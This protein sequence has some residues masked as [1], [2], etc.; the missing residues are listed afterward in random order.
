VSDLSP[1]LFP[2]DVVADRYR[3]S[4]AIGIGGSG[5]VYRAHQLGMKQEIAL[6]V[7]HA[8]HPD[9]VAER[10]RFAR[11]AEMVKRLQ[12]PHVVPLLDYGHGDDGVPFLVFALLIGQSLEAK[13]KQEGPLGWQATAKVS[14]QVLRALD[15]A[16]RLDI[17]HRD[18]KPA[19]IFMCTGV[20]GEVA[21]VLDFGL[22]KVVGKGANMDVTVAGSLLGT[23]RYMA[24]EQVRGQELGQSAD[25]YSFGLVMAEMLVGRPLVDGPTELDIF[26]L[27]GSD[28]PLT[29]PG[30]VLA[31]PFGPIIE[32]AVS[33]PV[34]VR[35]H[36]ASQM[37]ADLRA[38]VA[39]IGA[40]P[41]D[42][43]RGAD[44]EATAILDP[45]NLP[46]GLTGTSNP[47]AEKL[48]Q[49]FNTMASKSASTPAPA[50]AQ[51]PAQ[52]PAQGP[53]QAPASVAPAP[54]EIE[55]PFSE[56]ESF[57][58]SWT[59]PQRHTGDFS[60]AQLRAPVI[61]QD[62]SAHPATGMTPSERPYAA[63]GLVRSGASSFPPPSSCPPGPLPAPAD[64]R[65]SQRPR[66]DPS[67]PP[68]PLRDPRLQPRPRSSAGLV[69][70]LV[71]VL[72][73]LVAA[74]AFGGHLLGLL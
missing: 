25:I 39:H 64:P 15:K 20:L 30:E 57:P 24:P 27:H 22:A 71:I 74:G 18:I 11:E 13:I 43:P 12:H 52:R 1:D 2:G 46:F 19:N 37:L 58:E 35:Y 16:H 40:C 49:V 21:Q 4:E 7:M 29:I 34:S 72:L 33:K 55:D 42:D 66:F 14:D 69:V 50:P 5:T 36:L 61:E 48:R 44:L 10:Q 51:R 17:V 45:N 26:A 54:V 9:S 47:T 73:T 6:K 68:P 62:R 56:E 59:G 23:P 3:I 65:S 8:E 67:A 53:A 28:M 31:S 38:A 60:P 70:T 41:D 32:R 63:G